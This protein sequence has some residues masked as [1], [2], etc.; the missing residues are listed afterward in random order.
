MQIDMTNIFIQLGVLFFIMVLGY[1][2]KYSKRIDGTFDRALSKLLLEATVPSLI[3]SSVLNAENIPPAEQVLKLFGLSFAV[4]AILIVI[5]EIAVRVLLL[6]KG[7][8][9]VYRFATLFGNVGFVGFPVIS[10][11]FGQDALINAAMFNIPFNLLVFTL[12]P[13]WLMSDRTEK[14][15]ELASGAKLRMTPRM[16]ITP[17]NIACIA[18]IPLCLLGIHNVP[19]ASQLTQTVGAMTTPGALIIV[20]SNL[21]NMSVKELLG[22]PRVWIESVICLIL[23]PLAVWGVLHFFVS[24]PIILG[25]MVVLA[26][27][28]V[29]TNGTLLC[30]QYGGDM[31][32]MSQNTFITTLF[33]FATTPLLVLFLTMVTG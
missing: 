15:D 20:G 9:G 18:V 4:Y 8:R 21:A 13:I 7:R 32:G 29:A 14:V 11:I 30:F 16:F 10:A 12:G 28:P 23:S 3:L 6:P 5:G 31:K 1:F 33:S 22:G 2:L 26:G 17:C 19:V 25:C 24:D 27:M